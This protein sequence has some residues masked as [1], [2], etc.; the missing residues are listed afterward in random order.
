MFAKNNSHWKHIIWLHFTA[1][2]SV[3]PLAF[4][5]QPSL[6]LS[7]WADLRQ[8]FLILSASLWLLSLAVFL[9]FWVIPQYFWCPFSKDPLG[10]ISRL[11]VSWIFG[12]HPRCTELEVP[13]CSSDCITEPQQSPCFLPPFL[14]SG[15]DGV[16]TEKLCN[17]FHSRLPKV[18]LLIKLSKRIKGQEASPRGKWVPLGPSSTTSLLSTFMF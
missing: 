8:A 10:C 13:P 11:K 3:L 18:Q 6:T 16:S 4:W 5:S 17:L 15:I 1:N 12:H 9:E 14:R 7:Q 2:L